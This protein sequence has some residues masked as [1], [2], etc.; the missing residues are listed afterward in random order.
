MY[1]K[2][3]GGLNIHGRGAL[4]AGH[5][6]ISLLALKFVLLCESEEVLIATK[7]LPAV[8]Q[9][10]LTCTH[11]TYDSLRRGMPKQSARMLKIRFW[12][13]DRL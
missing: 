13:A 12:S 9:N 6:L 5:Y 1:L 10:C 7:L 4:G 3:T 2:G 11:K 8:S